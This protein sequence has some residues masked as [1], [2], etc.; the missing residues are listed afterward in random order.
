[1]FFFAEKD[2]KRYLAVLTDFSFRVTISIEILFKETGF[3][4]ALLTGGNPMKRLIKRLF[5][6][7]L[8]AVLCFGAYLVS[9]GYVMYKNATR[10][11]SVTEAVTA[12]RRSEKYTTLEDIPDIYEKAVIATEDHRFYS[13]P[14]VD[15]FSLFRALAENIKTKEFSQGGSTISQQVA[16]NM[17]FTNEKTLARKVAELFAVYELEDNYAKNVILELYMN[18]VYYGDGYYCIRDAARGYFGC[19]PAE[20]T[21]YQCTMLA[22]VP[23]APSVYAP[24]KNLE[25]AE[26][27]QEHVIRRM[28]DRKVLTQEEADTIL[29]KR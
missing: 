17:F 23:N 2:R 10:H 1:M 19:L 7:C 9:S 11:R 6:L 5:S 22:G 3:Q 4:I 29:S 25:L 28:V 15:P 26:K 21:D 16:K 20:M 8:V 27:R 24:T 14:G 18:T 12:L 13:H